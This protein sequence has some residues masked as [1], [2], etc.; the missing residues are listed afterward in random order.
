MSKREE[1]NRFK[2]L[3]DNIGNKPFVLI[4]KSEDGNLVEAHASKE[5]WEELINEF[6]LTELGIAFAMNSIIANEQ[7]GNSFVFDDVKRK[8]DEIRSGVHKPQEKCKFCNN[9]E[10][11]AHGFGFCCY[12]DR[13]IDGEEENYKIVKDEKGCVSYYDRRE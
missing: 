3:I 13:D 10:E 11:K 1:Q 2:E 6:I 8:I 12:L 5:G 7:I 9:F 4:T